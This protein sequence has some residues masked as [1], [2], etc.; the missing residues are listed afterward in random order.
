ME[1]NNSC[2]EC[3]KTVIDKILSYCRPCNSE[4]FRDNFTNW[5]SNDLDIDKLIQNSQLDATSGF[6]LIEWIEYSNLENIEFVANGGFGS[7]YKA[8]WKDGPIEKPFWN[9]DKSEWI[10]VSNEKV[11]IK[12]FR[13]VTSVSSEFLSEVKNNLVFNV[14]GC[15]RIYGVTRDPNNEEFAIV[16]KFQNNGDMR[17]FIKEKHNI[18][19]WRYI[20]KMLKD[21]SNGLYTVHSKEHHH[22]DFH[23]GNI[24]ININ[25]RTIFGNTTI[26]SVISDFGLCCP[27]NQN[28]ADK[29][30]Y[31]VL[32][33]VAPEVLRGGEFTETADIYGF[34][35][36]MSELISGEAPFADRDYD[37]H[38]AL[39]ICKG[40]RPSIPEYT[41]KSYAAL[42]KR[43]WDPI[44]TNRPAA[45]DLL[46]AIRDWEKIICESK[47][48]FNQEQED[49]WKARLAELASNKPKKSQDM[50]TSKKLD[51]FERLT[52]QLPEAKNV[53][54]KTN[55]STYYTRQ[56]DMSLDLGK[57]QQFDMPL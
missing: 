53:E 36:V 26:K 35:M 15:N 45:C 42:M 52:P 3:G 19:N 1:S 34:G 33:F 7:V 30:L 9:I 47:E 25:Y 17:K 50:L 44:P 16:T 20:I 8:I 23:S 51:Y 48:E 31:G 11:A 22:K 32:P 5:T 27:A 29:S 57:S 6:R 43:C 2:P 56:L 39:D 38:L 12:K 37:L 28:S 18:L 14:G 54:I 13:N 24:L 41:P 4:H 55:D 40:E 21:I 10:R 49:S 46:K